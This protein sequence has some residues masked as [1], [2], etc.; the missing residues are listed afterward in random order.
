MSS[1]LIGSLAIYLALAF[2]AAIVLYPLLLIVSTAIKDPLDVTANPFALFSSVS[3]LNFADA[4]TLGG[5]GG[6]I[7][8]T[9]PITASPLVGTV[10]LVALFS[11]ALARF[12]PLC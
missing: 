9:V 11:F 1:R 12:Y 8:Q 6:S 5:F 7:L 3:F 4:W 2:F 10:A